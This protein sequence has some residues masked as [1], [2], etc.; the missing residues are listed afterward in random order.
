MIISAL[1]DMLVPEG[2]FRKYCRLACGFAVIAVM[3][4]P[5][6]GGLSLEAPALPTLDTAA[7]EAGARARIL[8]AHR[9]NLEDI[10][11][12]RFPGCRAYIEVGGEGEVTALTVDG[13]E[14]ADA[15]RDF[16]REELGLG[17]D[18]VKINENT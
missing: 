5:A 4:S 9:E 6:T 15:V 14:D 12:A 3:L 17:E 10:V 13:A 16:A 1:A 2:S 11:E 8:T 7:A 18:R